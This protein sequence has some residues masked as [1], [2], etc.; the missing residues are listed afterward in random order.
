MCQLFCWHQLPCV[1]LLKCD[2]HI[3]PFNCPHLERGAGLQF[4]DNLYS[5]YKKTR[6][7]TETLLL[8]CLIYIGLITV[9]GTLHTVVIG[10]S[11][12]KSKTYHYSLSSISQSPTR[13]ISCFCDSVHWA[14]RRLLNNSVFCKCPMNQT[15]LAKKINSAWSHSWRSRQNQYLFQWRVQITTKYS[16]YVHVRHH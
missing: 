8:F 2:C 14:V 1:L 5:Q 10:T 3:L 16:P 15:S 7:I 11:F 12:L 9:K 4:W 6:F 13:K